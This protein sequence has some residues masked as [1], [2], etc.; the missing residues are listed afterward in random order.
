MLAHNRHLPASY[1]DV[2]PLCAHTGVRS[3]QGPHVVPLGTGEGA[4][5]QVAKDDRVT[6]VGQSG[7]VCAAWGPPEAPACVVIG[8]SV[9]YQYT[10]TVPRIVY[11]CACVKLLCTSCMAQSGKGP[12]LCTSCMAQSGKGP[13]L[14]TSC[15]A[16]SGKGPNLLGMELHQV[17]FDELLT[18]QF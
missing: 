5:P 4:E 16:Q 8:P 18:F 3:I 17:L 1:A 9:I 10:A 11:R 2:R 13:N 7:R 12:N 6:S 15:M 14:C